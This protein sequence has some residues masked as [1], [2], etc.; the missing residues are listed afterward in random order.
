M[1]STQNYHTDRPHLFSSECQTI[2]TQNGQIFVMGGKF[3]SRYYKTNIELIL[4]IFKD[5]PNSNKNFRNIKTPIAFKYMKNTGFYYPVK[6]SDM[7]FEKIHFG[8]CCSNL[9]NSHSNNS[10]L[11][12]NNGKVYIAGGQ[13]L[14]QSELDS[15][16]Q[17]N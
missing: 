7:P 12:M 13:N 14:Q 5:G 8:I 17:G 11:E 6:R 10:S 4:D 1:E 15:L 2:V 9:A 3:R 16:C